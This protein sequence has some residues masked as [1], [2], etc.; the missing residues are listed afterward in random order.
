MSATCTKLSTWVGSAVL[1][2]VVLAEVHAC[3]QGYQAA[4]C[5]IHLT[6]A[7]QQVPKQVQVAC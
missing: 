2:I 6:S 5:S 3:L 7:D 1:L 4:T